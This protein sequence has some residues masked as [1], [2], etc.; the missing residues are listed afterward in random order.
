MHGVCTEITYGV[1]ERIW[2][3]EKGDPAP[4]SVLPLSS[5]VTWGHGSDCSHSGVLTMCQ[6]L[7]RKRLLPS[8]IITPMFHI[9]KH[10]SS[11]RVPS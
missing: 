10:Y 4:V 7:Y 9:R 6:V 8:M 1:V 11:V 5:C 2:A 3:L